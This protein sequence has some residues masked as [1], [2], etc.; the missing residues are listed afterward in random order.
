[1][2]D[3]AKP[4]A[5]AQTNLDTIGGAQHVQSTTPLR[6]V[7]AASLFDGHDASINIMRRILQSLGVEVIHLAHNRSVAEVVQAALQEDVQG[8]ALSSY[9]GGHVEY[10]KYIIDMLKENGA[11]HIKVFGGGG[12]VIVPAEIE[13]LHAYGVE[14]IYSPQDGMKLGLVGMIEDMVKRCSLESA[15]PASLDKIED[16]S[17]YSQ[18][19][20]LITAIERG[21]L[22]KDRLAEIK[23]ASGN[24]TPVLG[25]TG[26]GGAGKSSLTDEMIRRFRVDS[27]DQAKIAI[28]AIDPT[29]R[30]TGGA[31]LGD[32]IRMNSIYADNIYMR[33]I[34]T[35]GSSGEVPSQLPEIIAATKQ[36]DFDLIVVETP[37]IGQGDA[38]IVPYVDVSMYVMTP[39]FGAQ[40]QL[41][42]ID[43]LDFADIVVINKFDRK[44]SDDA[45]RD[46][47]K[48]VQRN[49]DAWSSAPSDMPVYG[50]IA[51]RFGD[52][53]VTAAY[54]GLIQVLR[55][56]GLKEWQST[57]P[58]IDNKKPS[59]ETA[60]V[61]PKRQR[62]LAEIS[63]SVRRYHEAT[64]E[65]AEVAGEVYSLQE[66]LR[67]IGNNSDLE[68]ALKEK[69]QALA[70]ENQALL[71]SWPEI[72]ARYIYDHETKAQ[73]DGKSAVPGLA[74]ES[75]SGTL[76]SRV[77]VPKFKHYGELL[78][79]LRNENLP[80]FFPYAAGVFPYKREGED[81]ARMF[82][83][84]GDPAR[85]NRRF[86]R[87]S[88]HS[89]AKRLSTA[90]DSV[91]LYGF[92]PA[93]RP[94]IYGKIGNSG[95]SVATLDDMKQLYDGFDL[96]DPST[97]VSMTINGPAPTILAMF[98]NTAI[99]QQVD[100]FK[101]KESRDPTADE[102]KE[103][104]AFALSSVRGTVQADILK[105]DQG[106]NTCIFSTEFSLRMMGDIQQYFIN[107]DI[108]NFYSVSIS[109]YHIAEAGANPISQLAF[110]LAN[111]FTFVEAYLAR[112]MHIDDFASNLSFFFSNGMDPEY[113]VIGRVARRIWAVAMRDKYGANAKSQKL[114]YHIQTSGRSLHAQE[115]QFNDIRTTLQALLAIQDNCNSLHT[116]AF[117]EA[118]TTPTE[119]SVRRALAI[120]LIINREFGLAK[121]ENPYQGSFI[122]DELTDLVEEA[123]LQEF[124][125]ISDRGGVLGAMETG[126]QRGK[127][128]EESMKYETQKHDGTLPIIGVNTFLSEKEE[129]AFEIELARSTDAE[130]QSQIARLAEFHKRHADTAPQTI[131]VIKATVS[132]GG[133]G[134][135]AL[136]EAVR[137][138]SLGQLTDAFFEVGGQYR[139]ST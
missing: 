23:L 119:D 42:K 89:P 2:S 116:N 24:A 122:A 5:P 87:L 121:N 98:L 104:K 92:D 96:C 49:R 26:T 117:D 93:T 11:G 27:Q 38:G 65:Q 118:I 83:G 53:G 31:L 50:S 95:V 15:D 78:T 84:E 39:E 48:Q 105:E 125:R 64:V 16:R 75:L 85:T 4:Q 94:D 91:T 35:R 58:M 132:D 13:E 45:L 130:K 41:E 63:E 51:S 112:G 10:F 115:M 19:S 73:A 86:K 70:A 109:G 7:T 100:R 1:M 79:F 110:T 40:S 126:Y 52:D 72:K 69:Q 66:A 131:E 9:Q 8:I 28:I 46:V 108:R 128:Q 136:M 55:G 25:I 44:G 82:A 71:D 59:V 60:I 20:R 6:F 135:E 54:H 32:R 137:D 111:G 33:S 29:R 138:C 14:R 37:G 77:A 74:R 124:E 12:G 129:E 22:A 67:L 114:K 134:F 68:S 99:D 62:Y 88:E 102:Y 81:P 113:T 76:V 34:A 47:A 21:E 123:V 97:S 57:L 133:N 90:F 61:P 107:H 30:K 18:L 139:R 120:Q 56:K 127:I 101:D 3:A 43:M 17:N 36:Y 80:G 103:L 106:Q